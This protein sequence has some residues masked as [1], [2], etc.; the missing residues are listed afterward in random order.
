LGRNVYLIE[1]ESYFSFNNI[2]DEILDYLDQNSL[3]SLESTAITFSDKNGDYA[4]IY[5]SDAKMYDAAMHQY[6][7]NFIDPDAFAPLQNG[8]TVSDL[9]SYGTKDVGVSIAQ[10]ITKSKKNASVQEIKTK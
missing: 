9:T 10:T 1:E 6:L 8:G 4:E 7:S 5:V 3:Y 2:D